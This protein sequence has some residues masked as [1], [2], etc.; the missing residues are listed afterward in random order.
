TKEYLVAV[1]AA[2]H[3][4]V[5]GTMFYA[6]EVR[7]PKEAWVPSVEEPSERE[8]ELA[9]TFIEALAGDWDPARLRDAHR[10]RLLD[11][12]QSKA[13]EATVIPEVEEEAPVTPATDLMEILQASVDAARRA[14][15][16]E[17]QET[18]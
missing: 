16:A 1:R 6:D 4:L 18:G 3:V 11:L 14:R 10:E 2:E 12:L 5:L 17:D 13:G 7:D 9:R 8:L 15:D